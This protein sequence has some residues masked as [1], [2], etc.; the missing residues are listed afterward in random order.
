MIRP[1]EFFQEKKHQ[2]EEEFQH[3]LDMRNLIDSYLR[4]YQNKHLSS[5]DGTSEVVVESYQEASTGSVFEYLSSLPLTPSADKYMPIEWQGDKENDEKDK[6]NVLSM[7][8]FH[9][10]V[11]H[12]QELIEWLYKMMQGDKSDNRHIDDEEEG[13]WKWRTEDKQ[14]EKA[15]TEEERDE[16]EDEKDEKQEDQEKDE[17][18]DEEEDEDEDEEEEKEMSVPTPALQKL[19][20]DYQYFLQQYD[21]N[22]QD[23]PPPTAPSS[24][25]LS[26]SF[27]AGFRHGCY[28]DRQSNMPPSPSSYYELEGGAR[29]YRTPRFRPSSF[30]LTPAERKRLEDR[31]RKKREDARER[32]KKKDKDSDPKKDKSRPSAAAPPP[33]S[34]PSWFTQLYDFMQNI[35]EDWFIE[36]SYRPSTHASDKTEYY[37]LPASKGKKAKSFNFKRNISEPIHIQPKIRRFPSPRA[38]NETMFTEKLMRHSRKQKRDDDNDD[39]GGDD[40]DDGDHDDHGR[41]NDGIGRSYRN[42]GANKTGAYYA[43]PRTSRRAPP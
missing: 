11:Q 39:D 41:E 38:V 2:N 4:S 29:R 22:L 6:E 1:K 18:K 15:M 8:P 34:S 5:F 12:H 37:D 42:T 25:S 36:A 27:C 17:E 3:G 43:T 10:T 23:N 30:D 40:S 31:E 19:A 14:D 26:P 33:T 32:R 7:L 21:I 16:D 9:F 20:E 24:F 35:L 13:V 28:L